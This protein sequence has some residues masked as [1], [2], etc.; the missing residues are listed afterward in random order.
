MCNDKYG[1]WRETK[2]ER[3]VDDAGTRGSSGLEL[4]V[5]L[6]ALLGR[7]KG[8]VRQ[9]DP[10]VVPRD[11]S[12]L[13]A[14]VDADVADEVAPARLGQKSRSRRLQLLLAPSSRL[15]SEAERGLR[16]ARARCQISE[17]V[18]KGL[19]DASVPQ[20]SP[21]TSAPAD[22]C[23]TST[24]PQ[25]LYMPTSVGGLDAL[26]SRASCDRINLAAPIRLASAVVC[27][28]SAACPFQLARRTRRVNAWL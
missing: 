13:V 19:E 4:G 22:G 26:I 24:P 20:L 8:E 6:L 11:S 9:L 23:K 12:R 17:L 21:A 18:Q 15:R 5:A 16:D 10:V 7:E 2:N 14:R 25:F 28:Q 3:E 1:E 27:A